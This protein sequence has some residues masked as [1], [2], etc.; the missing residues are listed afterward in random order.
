MVLDPEKTAETKV[1]RRFRSGTTVEMPAYRRRV[2]AHRTLQML[3]ALI[4]TMIVLMFATA[5][6]STGATIHSGVGDS[7]PD[8]PPYFAGVIGDTGVIGHAPIT[9]Q[10]G[11][12]QWSMFDPRDGEGTAVAA[13]VADMNVFLD[14][15]S[16]VRLESST[17]Q[18][19][20]LVPPDVRFGCETAT[21]LPDDDCADREGALGRG[22]L[23]MHLSVGR[24]S[25]EWIEW[26]RQRMIECGVSRSLIITLE[27]SQYLTRQRGWSGSKEVDLGTNNVVKLPWLTSLETPV[28]VLQ[29]TGAVIDRDGKAIRIGAEG[30]YVRRTRLAVSAVGGQELMRDE[31]FVKARGARREDLAGSPLAWRVALENLVAGLTK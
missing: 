29:L 19:A 25:P 2:H 26:N 27:V 20:T 9:Y 1:V 3:I 31:D 15:I 18:K 12:S 14:S 13:L 8:G 7:F 11:A 22:R 6:A 5:C 23:P 21:R 30:F 28:M 4:A 17:T 16:W 24:P 10:R